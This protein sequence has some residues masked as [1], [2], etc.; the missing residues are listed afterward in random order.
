MNTATQASPPTITHFAQWKHELASKPQSEQRFDEWLFIHSASVLLSEKTGEL[1]NLSLAEMNLDAA[2]TERL[3]SQRAAS[4]GFDYQ[5]LYENAVSLKFVIY[6]PERLQ[7]TLDNCPRCVMCGQLNYTSPLFA[8]TFIEEVRERWNLHGEVPHE[9]GI[10]LGYPIED[11]FGYMGLLPLTCKGACGWLVY[12]NL[13]ESQRRS[14]LFN[15]A[16]CQALAF[17]AA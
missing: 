1:L 2:Q 7:S 5:I 17:L 13:Q 9:I 3:L 14:G 10:A 12:G 16:R 15:R 4:W 6:S 8:G 11:V